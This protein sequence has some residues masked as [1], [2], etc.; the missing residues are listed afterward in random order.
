MDDSL[1]KY[2]EYYYFS[3]IDGKIAKTILTYELP[4]EFYIY[5]NKK[6]EELKEKTFYCQGPS[7]RINFVIRGDSTEVL[8]KALRDNEDNLNSLLDSD[9]RKGILGIY[10]KKF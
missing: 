5:A 4:G 9:I 7:F 2:K 3:L 10:S 1:N 6:E 8:V